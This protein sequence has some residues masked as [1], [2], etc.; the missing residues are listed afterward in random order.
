M[1]TSSQDAHQQQAI[2]VGQIDLAG[3]RLGG[4]LDLHPG[5]QAQLDRL[6][7]HARRRR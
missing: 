3:L 1:Q 2:D 5:Q 7:G 4:V 6:L